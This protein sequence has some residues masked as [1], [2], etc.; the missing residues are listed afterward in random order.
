LS[1]NPSIA[2]LCTAYSPHVF[3][4]QLIAPT[5]ICLHGTGTFYAYWI[6]ERLAFTQLENCAAYFYYCFS[7][8]LSPDK[9]GIGIF[10]LQEDQA[11]L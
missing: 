7:G 11:D 3:L 5:A 8:K 4:P 1:G 2:Y 9:K 10:Y 6:R